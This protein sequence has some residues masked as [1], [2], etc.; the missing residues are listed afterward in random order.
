MYQIFIFIFFYFRSSHK[1]QKC[2]YSENFQIYGIPKHGI[3][4]W[5][6]QLSECE[7]ICMCLSVCGCN[8]GKSDLGTQSSSNQKAKP[9]HAEWCQTNAYL[10]CLVWMQNGET[11][12]YI[13]MIV[14]ISSFV[15]VQILSTLGVYTIVFLS[16]LR[17]T[18][19]G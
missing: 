1:S 14:V 10:R 2:F 16:K 4:K 12:C 9:L 13:N 3:L 5:Y 18:V 17:S 11:W 15:Y 7:Y 8:Y 6:P 19:I